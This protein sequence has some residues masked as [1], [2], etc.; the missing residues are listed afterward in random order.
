MK[1]FNLVID[2]IAEAREAARTGRIKLTREEIEA[3]FD[4][5]QS[6]IEPLWWEV[7][8]YD[9]PEK[10]ESDLS[11]FSL[12]QRYVLAI[13][14]YV[15]EVNNGGHDQFFFNSTG[16]VWKDALQGLKEIGHTQAARVLQ[17]AADQI[18][19]NPLLDREARQ[20][21]LDQY[22]ADFTRQD[23]GFDDLEDLNGAIMR[24]IK[25]HIEEF[26]C[27]GEAPGPE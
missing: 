20:D 21:I 27:E 9:G 10:Y 4:D 8:I 18:G 12:P 23:D 17:D 7:S 13:Q 15:A 22:Q 14:W 26:V 11:R 6:I 19:G 3:N 1:F 24:Y 16:I 25:A 5:P 2:Q